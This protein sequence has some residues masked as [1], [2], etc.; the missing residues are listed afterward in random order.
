[1][2]TACSYKLAE[3]ANESKKADKNYDIPD[4]HYSFQLEIAKVFNPQDSACFNQGIFL[5]SHCLY[6]SFF[7][8]IHNGYLAIFDQSLCQ[9]IHSA[10]ERS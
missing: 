6:I 9:K 8:Q 5:T 3:Q 10:R 7:V 4:T 2:I 1:L